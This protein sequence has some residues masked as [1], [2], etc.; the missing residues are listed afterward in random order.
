MIMS[1]LT[2]NTRGS[3]K[4]STVNA[5]FFISYCVGNIIGPFSFKETEA[6]QYT[7]GII[8]MLVTYCVEILLLLAFALYTAAMNKKRDESQEGATLD[9][10]DASRSLEN[11]PIEA[12][13]DQTDGEDPFFRYSY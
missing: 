4:R 12:T 8:A 1:L 6:P 3:T 13:L 9:L 2:A 7:S 10:Q 11:M 5:V